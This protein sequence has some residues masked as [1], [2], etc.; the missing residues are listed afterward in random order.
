MGTCK[1]GT[2]LQGKII[3]KDIL[4]HRFMVTYEC[5]CGSLVEFR[6][7]EKVVC[8]GCATRYQLRVMIGKAARP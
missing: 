4:P 6:T 5:R 7:E 1:L 8:R 3:Y 2:A